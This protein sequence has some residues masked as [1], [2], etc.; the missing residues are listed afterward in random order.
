MNSALV[1]TIVVKS[2]KSR[3]VNRHPAVSGYPYFLFFRNSGNPGNVV[4][5]AIPGTLRQ[6]GTT[7]EAD[8]QHKDQAGTTWVL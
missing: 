7:A 8:S 5:C 4:V 3:A 6:Y 2:S 1:R